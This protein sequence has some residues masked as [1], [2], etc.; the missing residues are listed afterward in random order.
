MLKKNLLIY[1]GPNGQFIQ[2]TTAKLMLN[3]LDDD[4]RD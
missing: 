3:A 4:W 1:L 2:M